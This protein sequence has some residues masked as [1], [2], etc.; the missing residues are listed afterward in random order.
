MWARYVEQMSPEETL[1]WVG[2]D[3]ERELNWA[4]VER[5]H[6]FV[7]LGFEAGGDFG[8]AGR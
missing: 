2:G 5:P 4:L 7:P 6:E 1:A 8:P 3:D